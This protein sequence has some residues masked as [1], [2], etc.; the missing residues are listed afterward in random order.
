MVRGVGVVL[1]DVN[2]SATLAK[3]GFAIKK[4]TSG[5]KKKAPTV[6]F[7]ME[8]VSHQTKP[9]GPAKP[10]GAAG[11]K[12]EDFF[13]LLMALLVAF[14]AL[15]YVLL[16]IAGIMKKYIFVL[17]NANMLPEN[18]TIQ[19]IQ[20]VRI[21]NLLDGDDDY[22][23]DGSDTEMDE[24][25]SAQQR[26]DLSTFF[27]NEVQGGHMPG[28]STGAATKRRISIRRDERRHKNRSPSR[29]WPATRWMGRQLQRR[30]GN[31]CELFRRY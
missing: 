26:R 25:E 21:K 5:E 6:R 31:R 20:T 12:K 13:L 7:L 15:F 1:H 30:C 2:V 16:R 17:N 8:M 27:N 11:K 24:G 3:V 10:A 19:A 29:Q 23:E 28:V 14:I 4:K 9:T 22:R 18:M